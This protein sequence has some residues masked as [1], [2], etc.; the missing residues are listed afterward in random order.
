[1]AA[2]P[3]AEFRMSDANEILLPDGRVA[4]ILHQYDRFPALAAK[5]VE[6]TGSLAAK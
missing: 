4:P 2:A 3:E 5:L 1:M 6:K